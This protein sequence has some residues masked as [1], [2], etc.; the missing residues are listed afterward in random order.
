[1]HRAKIHELFLPEGAFHVAVIKVRPADVGL[2]AELVA[3][4][5]ELVQTPHEEI[6]AAR[7]TNRE[8]ASK[9]LSRSQTVVE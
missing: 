3:R 1:M 7:W 6:L 9:F 5:V 4:G 2:D 8:W